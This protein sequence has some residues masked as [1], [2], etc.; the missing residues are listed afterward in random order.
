M[1][2]RFL[3]QILLLAPRVM[4]LDWLLFCFLLL[5]WFVDI[6]WFIFIL[7]FLFLIGK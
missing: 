4:K 6:I 7:L 5:F 2:Q 1:Q 3:L